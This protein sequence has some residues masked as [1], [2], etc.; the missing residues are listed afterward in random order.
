MIS[1]S[2]LKRHVICA[3]LVQVCPDRTGILYDK[4][5]LR[6]TR[7]ICKNARTDFLIVRKCAVP[8]IEIGIAVGFQEAQD[9]FA[10][11]AVE[12]IPV[13]DGSFDFLWLKADD[14]FVFLTAGCIEGLEV[15]VRV[16]VD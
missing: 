15:T 2:K 9:K 8:D 4:F 1:V 7:G 3:V 16:N 10:V 11:F 14:A 12:I 5:F 6:I 13:I